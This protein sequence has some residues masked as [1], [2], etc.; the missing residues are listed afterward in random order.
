MP[1]DDAYSAAIYDSTSGRIYAPLSIVED[2]VWSAGINDRGS[3]S[4]KVL[5][6]ASSELVGF[7]AMLAS[8]RFSVVIMWNEVPLQA[9]PIITKGFDDPASTVTIGG[10]GAW[11]L[12]DKRALTSPTWNPATNF[13]TSVQADVQVTDTLPNIART[14]VRNSVNMVYR[15]GSALPWDVPA[16][17]GTGT[18]YR[19]YPGYDMVSVGQR[20]QELTQVQNGPDVLVSP[21]RTSDVNGQYIRHRVLVGEPYLT[22][23]GLSLMFDYGSN[24]ETLSVDEDG[25][26]TATTVFVKGS[27]QEREQTYARLQD[28]RL[29]DAGWPM[30]DFVDSTHS[31]ATDQ[32]TLDDWAAANLALSGHSVETWDVAVRTRSSTATGV[33]EVAALGSYLPGYFATI[34]IAPNH[35][36]RW[37][38]AGQYSSRILAIANGSE[39]GKVKLSLETLR[40]SF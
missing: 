33:S 17:V 1:L 24:L 34:N 4:V 32:A 10:K 40:G 30:L 18:N 7:R 19:F 36:H 8:W 15:N 2:P 13:I 26:D 9:G 35:R 6:P 39:S 27:G 5:T 21:Y 31:T 37:I 38:P 22:Q 12:L 29:T 28:S 20:L 3:W 23:P 25:S 11:S 16:N 14:L